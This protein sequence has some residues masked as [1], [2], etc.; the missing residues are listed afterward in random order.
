[1]TMTLLSNENRHRAEFM[2]ANADKR[3]TEIN[4]GVIT[5]YVYLYVF[6][7]TAL[8]DIVSS[9]DTASSWP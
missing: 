3:L 2:N 8:V 1:M 5:E 7:R 4:D 9:V 6:Q